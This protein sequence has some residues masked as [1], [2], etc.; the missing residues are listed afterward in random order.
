[1]KKTFTLKL[2]LLIIMSIV[3][4]SKS[5]AQTYCNPSVSCYTFGSY[6][7]VDS[8]TVGGVY[9]YWTGCAPT[10]N[11]T[12]TAGDT[13]QLTAGVNAPMNVGT[14]YYL[15]LAVYIDLNGN[16][17]FEDAGEMLYS[18]AYVSAYWNFSFNLQVPSNTPTGYYRMRVIAPDFSTPTATGTTGPCGT[19]TYGG[20]FDYT[21]YV[22]GSTCSPGIVTQPV[23]ATRCPGGVDTFSIQAIGSAL[24][25]QWNFNGVALSGGTSPSLLL[26]N[27]DSTMAGNYSCTVTSTTCTSGSTVSNSATLT[28]NPL[29]IVYN[30]GPTV[31]CPGSSVTLTSSQASGNQWQMNGTNIYNATNQTLVAS[32]PGVYTVVYTASCPTVSKTDTIT[33]YPAPN[34]VISPAGIA[35]VLKI[36]VGSTQMLTTTTDPTWSYQWAKNNVKSWNIQFK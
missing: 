10:H 31:F 23:N 35:G 19:F 36:C 1:M 28:V 12:A 16:G 9:N 30:S 15:G 34:P 27:I 25:Y 18:H 6:Y 26:T 3:N 20:W 5:N 8:I 32:A 29:P 11:Y 14:T 21:V 17:S 2:L 22:A 7:F 13:V 33:N 24:T 4:F